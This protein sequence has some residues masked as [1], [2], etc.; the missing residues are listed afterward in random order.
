LQVKVN[1]FNSVPGAANMHIHGMSTSLSHLRAQAPALKQRG[2]QHLAIF[3]SRARGDA[4][5][6]SDLDVLV[7]IDPAIEPFSL[8][9]LAGISN[10]LSDI[11]GLR[12]VAIE[13][14][15]LERNPEAAKRIEPDIIEVF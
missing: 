15:M 2:V 11:T 12:V 8:V 7:D 13:R 14:R 10:L 4:S 5:E 6:D 9:D 3:G 1:S